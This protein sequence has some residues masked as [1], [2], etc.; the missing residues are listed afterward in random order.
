MIRCII[1]PCNSDADTL[2]FFGGVFRRLKNDVLDELPSKRRQTVMLSVNLLGFNHSI[3]TAVI[4][5]IFVTCILHTTPITLYVPAQ[6]TIRSCSPPQFVLVKAV[7]ASRPPYR[8]FHSLTFVIV[9]LS[10]I[11]SVL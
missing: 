2:F 9:L 8:R 6:L 4:I 7:I 5:C 10:F 1:V 11:L 3:L